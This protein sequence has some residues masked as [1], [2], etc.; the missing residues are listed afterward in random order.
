MRTDIAGNV[1]KEIYY[2]PFGTKRVDNGSYEGIPYRYTGQYEDAENDL[3]YYKKRYYD[4]VI[5]RFI[6]ADPLY[7]SEIDE[8]GVSSLSTNMYAYVMNSP[9]INVDPTGLATEGVGFSVTVAGFGVIGTFGVQATTDDKGNSGLV[10]TLGGGA[11]VGSSNVVPSGSVTRDSTNTSADNIKQL[12][13]GSALV[14]GTFAN[15]VAFAQEGVK[16]EGYFGDTTSI[17][18]GTLGADAYNMATY[19]WVTNVESAEKG[20]VDMSSLSQ[21]INDLSMMNNS[22]QSSAD[23]EMVSE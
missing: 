13:G 11:A 12:A 9:L 14:G 3:Y 17:G 16:G 21:A 23:Q 8:R 20:N 18:A 1:V 7:L 6:S 10:W 15:G 4:P 2:N 5:G 19:S 22:T